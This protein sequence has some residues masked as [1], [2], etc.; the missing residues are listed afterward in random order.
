MSTLGDVGPHDDASYEGEV[1][2]VPLSMDYFRSKY[3]EFQQALNAADAAYA[4]GFVV[5]SETGDENLANLI[6]EYQNS[7]ET[8]KSIAE[9]MNM[10][11]AAANAIGVR[12]PVLSIPQTLGALPAFVVPAVVAASLTAA[13][14]WSGRLR[15]F[16]IGVAE[17]IA[18]ARGAAVSAGAAP[19]VIAKIDAELVKAKQSVSWFDGFSLSKLPDWAKLLGIGAL[20]FLAYKSFNDVFDR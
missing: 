8:I 5:Y 14:Y 18:Q 4:A 11:A 13:V 16:S 20:A 6:S 15:G 19:E 1:S 9:T 10:G 7:A 17:G 12:L 2:T 3:L